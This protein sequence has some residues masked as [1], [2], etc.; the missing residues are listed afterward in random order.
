MQSRELRPGLSGGNN[1]TPII[2]EIS[3]LCFGVEQLIDSLSFLLLFIHTEFFK[4][5]AGMIELIKEI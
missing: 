4:R 5:I 3:W 2:S 1:E